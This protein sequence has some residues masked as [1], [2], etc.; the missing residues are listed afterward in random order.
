MEYFYEFLANR[1]DLK[2]SILVWNF[3]EAIKIPWSNRWRHL[4]CWCYIFSACDVRPTS[5]FCAIFDHQFLV[6]IVKMVFRLIS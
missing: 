4:L 2:C 6:L 1:K 3:D 5:T